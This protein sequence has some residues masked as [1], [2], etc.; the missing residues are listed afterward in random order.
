M[1]ARGWSDEDRRLYTLADNRLA[2]TSEW[3]V[4]LL[5]I[6]LDELRAEVGQGALD[7]IAFT[8]LDLASILPAALRETGAT[9]PDEVPPVPETPVTAT[10]D[11]WLLGEH[12]VMCGD[13]TSRE[14]IAAL[15]VDAVDLWLTD[16]PYNV[17]YVG[18]TKDALT[19]QN[20]SMTDDQFRAFLRA[21]YLAADAVMRPGAAFYIWHADSEGF[22]FRGAARDVGWPVRQCL[23][24]QK[25][26]FVM[27]RQDYQWQHEP[28]LYGWKDGA[29]HY[30]ASDRKQTTLLQFD[31]PSRSTE[32]PTMKPV[33]LFAY[34]MLNNTTERDVVL[35]SF[36]GS[37]TTLIACEQ[38]NRR[39]RLMEL[40]PKY[41][42]VIV[43]RWQEFTGL[44]AT[45]EETGQTFAEVEAERAA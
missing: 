1:I 45:L 23:I 13:S 9:D 19:I 35:D 28:C 20:D 43:K 24:W 33:D 17:A 27:G 31:K 26:V 11:V 42:D 16:P 30:W 2:E 40:D 36:G 22:N 32:H 6:E 38:H 12:R 21:S 34:Q 8:D 37:G 14:Q 7:A 25:S 41:C 29:A 15:C 5:R 3:D 10:G 18:K 39:A 4:G 44:E